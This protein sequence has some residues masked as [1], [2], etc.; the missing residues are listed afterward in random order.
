M[1]NC[2]HSNICQNRFTCNPDKCADYRKA[3]AIKSSIPIHNNDIYAHLK[4]T[5]LKFKIY[6]H[7]RA[8]IY[9]DCL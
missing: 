5:I 3:S 6:L 2:I 8:F 7:L 1:N 9:I 4:K